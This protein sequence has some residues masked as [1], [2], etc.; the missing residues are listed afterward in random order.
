MLIPSIDLQNGRVVQLVQGEK[1]ALESHDLEAWIA[2]FAK[3]PVVQLIDLDAAMGT[4]HNDD[5]VRKVAAALPVRAGGGVR[6][7]K[8]AQELLD[9]GAQ[10]VIVGSSLFRHVPD[11]RRQGHEGA[12]RWIDLEF[13]RRLADAVGLDRIIGAVDAKGGR[14]AVHGWKTLLPLTAVEAVRALDPYCGGFLYTHVDLEGLM[15]GTDMNAIRAVASATTRRVT[16]AGGIT[17]RDEIDAL[18]AFGI[19]A[20]VGMAIY[21][22]ALSID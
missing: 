19:D 5:L 8:R 13:A 9:A 15:Q 12:L 7:V 6:T 16:A 18:D 11:E 1:L 17:T 3:F 10:A 20:V 14:V 4:G 2:R 21:T 22:G